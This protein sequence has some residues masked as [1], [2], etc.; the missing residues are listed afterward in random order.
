MSGSDLCRAKFKLQYNDEVSMAFSE[1]KSFVR[2]NSL[3][4][5][6]TENK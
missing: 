3:F 1:D 6:M 4:S 5:L 2:R